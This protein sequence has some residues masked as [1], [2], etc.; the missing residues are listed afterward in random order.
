MVSSPMDVPVVTRC[1]ATVAV[2]V[3]G[4][5]LIGLHSGCRVEIAVRYCARDIHGSGNRTTLPGPGFFVCFLP[6]STPEVS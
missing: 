3:H 5:V 6:V 1:P 4:I 2:I